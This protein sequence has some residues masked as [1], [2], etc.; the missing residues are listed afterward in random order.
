MALHV[1]LRMTVPEL[2]AELAPTPAAY[3]RAAR[4]ID[5]GDVGGLQT[6]RVAVL[7]T[8]TASF[9]GPYLKVE[10]AKRGFDFALWFAPW[11]QLEEQALDSASPL[12]AENP[13]AVVILARL[14]ELAASDPAALRDRMSTLLATLRRHS[15]ARIL[16]ANFAPPAR[17]GA[18]LADPSLALSEAAS[19]QQ[20]NDALAAVCRGIPDAFVFDLAR[21][22]AEQGLASWVDTRLFHMARLPISVPAQIA[23][24]QRL[25]RTLRAAFVPPA[26][27][28][29]LDLDHTLWG[30][31]LGEDGVGGIGL[32]DEFPGNVFKSW[33]R[34]LRTL[35]DR[36]VLLAICS[37]NN[38]AE[39]DEVFA[40]HAD[41]IL[42]RSDF[43]ALRINWL[44]KSENL[45]SLAAELNLG[46]DAL[47][48]LDDSAFEREEIRAT[49]PMVH[50]L[51]F[52]VSPLGLVDAVEESG[53]F[54][55][56]TLSAEDRSRTDMYRQQGERAQAA[57]VAASPEEFLRSLE[58]VAMIGAVDADTLPRIAQLLAKTNQFNL[59]TR[60][61]SA[62][63]V[64]AF[65]DAGAIALW[66]RLSDKFGDH[67][68]V[69]A[70]IVVPETTDA[71]RI[72]TLLL[73][74]R[75][76]GRGVET[77]L[78][79]RLVAL[80]RERGGQL[81]IGEYIPTA[82]NSLVADFY[83]SHGFAPYGEGAWRLDLPSNDVA[84]PP[85]IRLQ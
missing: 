84:I 69:G 34:Y 46:L 39:V 68:L 29:V 65:I 64:Q 24:A 81:A 22:V 63:E 15:T 42:Q 19:T 61:H 38:E 31:I 78:L 18:G 74:C 60:R 40:R 3:L 25:A 80:I 32:G 56:L 13:E 9:L 57:Q 43:A 14:E 71:W 59:T 10:G 11:G 49:L 37:K 8:F 52:P 76:I 26:R 77:A 41:M 36:G 72:D 33:Q 50:V 66:L 55:R 23:L 82:K 48:F 85:H 5:A 27:V 12:Y 20:A 44:T 83:P 17:L 73:S 58:L 53:L 1:L 47:V 62:A 16:I 6:L 70:A 28:L 67:G 54:D 45:R 30:G 51:D 79:A 7:S 4:R 35:R 2:T 75:V 21:L